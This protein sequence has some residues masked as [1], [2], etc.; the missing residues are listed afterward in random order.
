MG[1]RRRKLR[2]AAL[3]LSLSLAAVV[4]ACSDD[5][6]GQTDSSATATPQ[7]QPTASAS[8]GRLQ[9]G[10][11]LRLDGAPLEAEF[12][13]ARVVRDGLVTFCQAEI[14]SVEGGAYSIPVMAE[15]EAA[16]CGAPGA[17][18]LLWTFVGDRYLF[19]TETAAWPEESGT[20]AFD[21]A[22]STAD[23]EGA[24]LPVTEFKGAIRDAAGERPPEGTLVEVFAGDVRCGMASTRASDEEI[25]YTLAAA[26][27]ESVVGCEVDVTL[28]FLVDGD[29]APETATND[30]DRGSGGHVLD[31]TVP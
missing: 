18:V 22:F 9:M 6:A 3:L 7:P 27:P 16:G 31:L 14:P 21:G 26:G 23:P 19:S 11:L 8:E 25:D 2:V 15:A 20:L 1:A 10:G 17:D 29:P 28:T 5:D 30:L 4:L 12:L 13:G 24:S